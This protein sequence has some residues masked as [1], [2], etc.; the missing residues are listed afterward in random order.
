MSIK[1]YKIGDIRNGKEILPQEERKTILFLSDLH[2][3]HSGLGSQKKEI[4]Y[5]TCH[6]YNYIDIGFIQGI[7]SNK[8][9][10]IQDIGQRVQ[11]ETGVPD[12]S[13]K[14]KAYDI[15]G[16]DQ[17]KKQKDL[18]AMIEQ[19]KPDAL[20]HFT[21]PHSWYWMYEIQHLIRAKIPIIY[22]NIWDNLPYPK[23]NE[24]FYSCSDLIM[25]ISKQTQ[26]LVNNICV[27]Y[28]REPWQTKYIPHGINIE[29]FKP[30]G[31]NNIQYKKASQAFERDKY[32][33]ILLFV[34][35]NII[36]KQSALIMQAWK[37]FCNN[38][39]TPQQKKR[40]MLLMKTEVVYGPGMP[41][42]IYY[43][44]ILHDSSINIKF[45]SH[46]INQQQ[47]NALYNISD[48]VVSF[49]TA[50]GFGLST[51]EGMAC[52]KPFIAPVI[53]GLQDQMGFEDQNG[54]LYMNSTE[55]PSNC[56]GKL[57]KHKPWVIPIWFT[58]L[59]ATG[60]M[61]TPYIY[62]MYHSL[63]D[64]VEAIKK[65]YDMG[66]EQRQRVGLQARE[67]MQTEEVKMTSTQ[68]AQ[69][70]M[71]SIDQLFI[72]WKPKTKYRKFVAK[73]IIK[74]TNAGSYNPIK[75]IWE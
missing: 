39:L 72:H 55:L 75:E 6:R 64:L 1:K 61:V 33:F 36:R 43:E 56:Y 14:I 66:K 52:G 48:A 62:E 73:P 28:K 65:M 45:I 5:E 59:G 31:K 32:D 20:F 23:Y 22:Y 49:S 69:S 67:W 38:Y 58:G 15:Y 26:N 29:T 7:Q 18:L 27:N 3:R 11:N 42:N 40:V 50:Q 60:S 44:D 71:Q 46:G 63:K 13:L 19:F 54:N 24:R 53:G 12:V 51:A 17:V 37:W 10:P 9:Y 2:L 74:N 8:D 70:M 21:D 30:L 35:K 34:N 68:M 57:K 4:M 25:N 47:L 16:Q 41:L